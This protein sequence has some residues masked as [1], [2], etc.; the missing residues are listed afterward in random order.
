MDNPGGAIY[1]GSG[2]DRQKGRQGMKQMM[3]IG[4]YVLC[5]GPQMQ[6]LKEI[7]PFRT[8][9]IAFEQAAKAKQSGKYAHVEV[10]EKV[11]LK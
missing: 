1:G 5:Y 7:G 6:V 8:E 3:S 9:G 2:D 11:K 10:A 4:L